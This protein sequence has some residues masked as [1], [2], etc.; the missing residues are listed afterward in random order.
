M[1]IKQKLKYLS[2]KMNIKN[3]IIIINGQL[4]KC[5]EGT[6]SQG[7]DE[8]CMTSLNKSVTFFWEIKD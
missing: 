7:I 6:L 1:M 5:F 3:F 4:G 2:L 8:Y